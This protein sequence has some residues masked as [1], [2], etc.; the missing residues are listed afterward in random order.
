M[1]VTHGM[2]VDEVTN[3]G[4]TLQS[5]ASNIR[6]MVGLLEGAISGTTWMG[7][8]ADQFK[9]QWWPEHKQHL[10]AVA[11]QLHGFGQSAINN[12]TDQVTASSH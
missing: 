11:E 5:Q 2:N 7:P 8:D 4:T 12:A 9:G 3:L 10:M 6:D 1:A